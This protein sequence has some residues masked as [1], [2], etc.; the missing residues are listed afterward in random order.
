MTIYYVLFFFGGLT[1]GAIAGAI[2]WTLVIARDADLL[3]LAPDEVVIKKPMPELVLVQVTPEVARRLIN[4]GGDTISP[5]KAEARALYPERT[6]KGKI[7]RP[8]QK[9]IDQE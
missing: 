1:V 3:K 7:R 4:F 5:N 8:D 2:G 6:F 9:V